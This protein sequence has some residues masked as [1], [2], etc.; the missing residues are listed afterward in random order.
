MVDSSSIGSDCLL[1]PIFGLKLPD[2]RC[3]RLG[4]CRTAIYCLT[5]TFGDVGAL[6]LTLEFV[7]AIPLLIHDWMSGSMVG[8]VPGWATSRTRPRIDW[9]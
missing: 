6:K 9:M 7:F 5:S 2:Y 8:E 1:A 4:D 3:Y